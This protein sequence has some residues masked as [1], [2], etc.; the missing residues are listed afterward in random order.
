[1][2]AV[3]SPAAC[4]LQSSS[5]KPTQPLLLGCTP[6]LVLDQSAG[7]GGQTLLPAAWAADIEQGEKGVPEGHRA[8]RI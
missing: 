1:M 4:L 2:P 6:P 8:L 5:P 7:R 3:D